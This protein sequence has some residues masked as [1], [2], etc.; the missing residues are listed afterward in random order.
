MTIKAVLRHGVIQ[1]VDPLPPDWTEGQELIVEEPGPDVAGVE[2]GQ[3]VQ[4]MD[5]ATAQL[6][7][8]EHDRFRQALDQI[9]QESKDAVRRQWGL[10]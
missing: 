3:W 8:E 4:E 10:P 6:P 2:I 1:P 9:E 5:A 7:H